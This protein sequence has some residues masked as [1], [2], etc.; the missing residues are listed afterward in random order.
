MDVKNCPQIVLVVNKK[1]RDVLKGW[2]VSNKEPATKERFLQKSKS[3]KKCRIGLFMFPV[4]S[5][6][7]AFG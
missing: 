7:M 4:Y 6:T 3:G 2:P 1:H 5:F